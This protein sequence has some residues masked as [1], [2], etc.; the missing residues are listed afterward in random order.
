M[1]CA[2]IYNLSGE[3]DDISHLF[4]NERLGRIAAILRSHDIPVT[5]IDRANLRDLLRLGPAYLQNLGE[6]EFGATS[7]EHEAVVA[8]E[9]KLILERPVDTLFLHLWHGTGFT[10]SIDLAR[11]LKSLSRDLTIIGVGQKVDWFKAHILRLA[12][13]AL[14]GLITGLGYDAIE[15][16]AKGGSPTDCPSMI[17]KDREP[18]PQD[19]RP[20]LDVDA[21]PLADYSTDVYTT[22]T[23]KLPLHSITLSNQACP[24]RCVFCIR[25]ENYGR[26]NVKRD[27]QSVIDE[28]RDLRF[29]RGVRH[30]RIEDS[31]PPP[32]ALSELAR[33]ILDSDLNGEMKFSA[34]A[35]IDTNRDED[36]ALLKQAGFL[37]LFLGI[38]SLDDGSLKRIRKG[39]RYEDIRRALHTAHAAGLKTVGSFIFPLPEETEATMQ[40]TLTRLREIREDLDSLLVLPAG[41]YPDTPWG[42]APEEHGILLDGNF[43]EAFITYPLKYLQPIHLW[44]PVPFTYSV[45]GKPAEDVPFS[46]ILELYAEFAKVA[47]QELR[48]PPIP[49]YYYLLA[50]MMGAPPAEATQKLV[51]LMV[52]RDYAG[53]RQCFE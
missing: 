30:V 32:G 46:R 27:V 49:D 43:I 4:P 11:R 12:P 28:L 45:M 47:R 41:V 39:T 51:Q 20:V 33:S 52:A 50:D 26:V 34:F 31:T 3:L 53:I 40:T 17:W 5:V 8:D 1:H 9:A 38:E 35:R 21:F 6:L 7:P 23:D 36:F 29:D 37:A 14:D 10:F 18:L 16:L 22:I 19:H 25:P 42:D 24:N 44:P 13:D 2:L 48:L 15:F